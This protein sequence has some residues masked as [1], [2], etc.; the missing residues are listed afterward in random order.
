MGLRGH[1]VLGDVDE[2]AVV[3]GERLAPDAR[4]VAAG[5][6]CRDDADSGSLPGARLLPTKMKRAALKTSAA[7]QK[8]VAGACNRRYQGLWMAE[9][10]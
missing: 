6:S 10:A 7:L 4:F 5:G 9:V 1:S 2:E 3:D 8:L